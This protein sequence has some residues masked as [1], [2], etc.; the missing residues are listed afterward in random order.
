MATVHAVLPRRMTPTRVLAWTLPPMG[1]PHEQGGTTGGTARGE[2][3]RGERWGAIRSSKSPD[4]DLEAQSK[5]EGAEDGLGGASMLEDSV[6][7]IFTHLEVTS[8]MA[9]S[10]SGA[11]A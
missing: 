8:V 6:R 9:V 7:G 2:V 5:E 11:G 3:G 4:V 10:S 1:P